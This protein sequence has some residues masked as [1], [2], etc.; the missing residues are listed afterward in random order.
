[1]PQNKP[2][3]F[4]ILNYLTLKTKSWNDLN[5]EEKKCIEPYLIHRFISMEKEYVEVVNTVQ[6]I[7]DK[8]KVY[9]IYYNMLPKKTKFF[10]YIKKVKTEKYPEE[11]VK[12]ISNYFSCSLG[13]AE[14]YISLLKKKGVID[15]LNMMGVDDKQ[16]KKLTKTLE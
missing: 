3:I 10:K 7:S 2:T 12:N 9:K 14:E 15:I 4:D 8:E 1:M 6:K 5:D 13:E 11:V 16:V